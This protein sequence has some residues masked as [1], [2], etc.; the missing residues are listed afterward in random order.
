MV[1]VL[2]VLMEAALLTHTHLTH[3]FDPSKFF[4]LRMGHFLNKN[5]LN[6][7]LHPIVR[8]SLPE[9]R[10]GVFL[11]Y[12]VYS[13]PLSSIQWVKNPCFNGYGSPC[14]LLGSGSTVHHIN[15]LSQAKPGFQLGRD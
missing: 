7:I 3:K 12:M 14:Y 10:G 8:K 6:C 11:G 2:L 9:H 15:M 5:T 4:L 13:Q 1:I